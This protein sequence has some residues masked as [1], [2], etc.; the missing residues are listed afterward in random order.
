V[1]IAYGD[2]APWRRS[3]AARSPGRPGSRTPVS[4]GMP[5]EAADL[6]DPAFAVVGQG[7]R[8]EALCLKGLVVEM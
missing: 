5:V 3:A 1:T 8:T 7:D 6:D 2:T 4:A